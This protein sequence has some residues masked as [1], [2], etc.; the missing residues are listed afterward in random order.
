MLKWL[1]VRVG[2]GSI[3]I[4]KFR[5]RM[6]MLNNE[7]I[8]L[9]T[10][11]AL[12]EQGEGKKNIPVGKYFKSDYIGMRLLSS[13]IYITIADIICLALWFVVK[14]EDILTR[15]MAGEVAPILSTVVIIYA[16]TVFVYMVASYTFFSYKFKSTRRSL[17]EY[18]SQLKQLHN[19]QERELEALINDSENDMEMVGEE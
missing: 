19:L 11:L 16:V 10:K 6:L 8:I 2:H 12:Y 18:N 1:I 5:G 17:K 7:K 9:M 3:N 13:F 4:G 15:L 14:G